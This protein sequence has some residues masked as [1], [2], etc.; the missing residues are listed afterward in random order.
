MNPQ[1]DWNTTT[2]QHGIPETKPKHE[3]INTGKAH[4]Q[5]ATTTTTTTTT[6]KYHNR[7][8]LETHQ[9]M[10]IEKKSTNKWNK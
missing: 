5:M 2:K 1:L 8:S 3:N 4:I 9:Q 10:I 6:E 7:I